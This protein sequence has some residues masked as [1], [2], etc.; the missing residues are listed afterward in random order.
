MLAVGV[1]FA[2]RCEG[3]G[4]SKPGAKDTTA[5]NQNG[6]PPTLQIPYQIENQWIQTETESRDKESPP[7]YKSPEWLLGIVGIITFGVI[8]WQSFETRRT[9]N[10]ASQANTDAKQA[11]SDALTEI[12]RQAGL[13][14]RQAGLME[15]QIKEARESSDNAA[16]TA[17][18]T[19]KVIRR[20]ARHVAG[21]V[22]AME[23]QATSMR[24]QNFVAVENNRAASAMAQDTLRSLQAQYS[25]MTR[26]A[27]LMEGQLA[28]TQEAR[29]QADRHVMAT[30]RPW[31][32]TETFMN[33]SMQPAGP[34]RMTIEARVSL[35][36]T[37]RSVAM[38]GLML[39]FLISSRAIQEG[40]ATS[41]T[42]TERQVEARTGTNW[43]S[44]FV[45]RP[46]ATHWHSAFMGTEMPVHEIRAGN[47]W[48][49][50]C[51]IY[52]DQFGNTH[53]T[54]D[55]FRVM[56]R[57]DSIVDFEAIPAHQT[58]D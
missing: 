22:T 54:Q 24:E 47:S 14:E 6:R 34:D 56:P 37:G 18:Y 8:G 13:M 19:L 25:A 50:V 30:E 23:S 51:I 7:W 43:E 27:D 3:Q 11:N 48:I 55:C 9:A 20:Q 15:R 53:R 40:I 10:A 4:R 58:A 46:G 52:S 5:E 49:L 45:L 16:N 1:Y 41:W 35:R 29:A 33:G 39:P 36:N 38:N 12:R 31:I 57:N 44:G 2:P 21:Q 17:N 42:A 26:Q 32:G 28:E